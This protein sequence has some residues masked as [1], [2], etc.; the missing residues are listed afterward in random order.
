MTPEQA[1]A[2]IPGM[3]GAQVVECLADG[4]TNGT[5]RVEQGGRSLVLRCDKAAAVEL[6]LNRAN[7]KRIC[8]VAAAAGLTPGYDWFD[9]VAGTCLRRFVPGR[10]LA[11]ADL[12]QP[13]TLRRLAALLRR[14]HTLPASGPAFDPAGAAQRYA[15]RLASPEARRLAAEAA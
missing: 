2:Q 14:L 6:G 11:A 13:A 9:P 7:E 3:A 15:D 10:S 1:L 4:P 5:W 8:E 12:R